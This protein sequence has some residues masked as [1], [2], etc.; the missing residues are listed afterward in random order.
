MKKQRKLKRKLIISFIIVALISSLASTIQTA[1]SVSNAEQFGVALNAYGFSQGHIAHSMLALAEGRGAVRDMA[2]AKTGDA[3][4][5][6]EKIW[7]DSRAVYAESIALTN[8]SIVDDSE[9]EIVSRLE[10]GVGALFAAQE[11]WIATLRNTPA[12]ERDGLLDELDAEIEPLYNSVYAIH[13]ELLNSKMTLGIARVNFLNYMTNVTVIAG[14]IIILAAV[15]AAII[16]GI[17][18]ARRIVRSVQSLVGASQKLSSG[19]LDFHVE[20]DSNDELRTLGD[21]FNDMSRSFGLIINDIQDNLSQLSNGNFDV[22]STATDYYVGRFR[23]LLDAQETLTGTLSS[24]LS[25]INAAAEQV[26]TGADQVASGAQGLSQGTTEQASAV[27]QLAATLDEINDHVQKTGIYATKAS[28]KTSE[29]GSMMMGCTERMDE[30]LH[31]IDEIS[32]SSQEIGKIIKTIEDIAFQTNI[33]AL[34]AAVEAARA[35]AAGKGFAVVADEVRSLAA[36]SAEASQNTSALIQASMTAVNN[37]VKIATDTAEQLRSVAANAQ[38]VSEMVVHIAAA[39]QEQADSIAQVTTGIDQISS[40]VQTNSATAEE[41]AAASQELS[42]QSNLLKS[43]V[44]Q[45]QLRV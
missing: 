2:S 25:R 29:A 21:A 18:I 6:C 8:E 38:E 24:T 43:L 40:V 33:L 9:L 16:F 1:Q 42:S 37:G 15:I 5:R 26:A 23:G 17:I 4:N 11:K 45:F 20:I 19:Q 31:A 3:L 22:Q 35:G 34:N 14:S 44:E 30:M 41:S 7:Q 28:E 13:E 10:S 39:S 32:R 36:K 12:I 27:E